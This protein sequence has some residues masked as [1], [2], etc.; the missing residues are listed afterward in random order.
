MLIVIKAEGFAVIRA[1]ANMAHQI[2]SVF[3]L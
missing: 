3:S 2:L 1:T